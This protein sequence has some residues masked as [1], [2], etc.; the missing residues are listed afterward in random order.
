MNL[1][2]LPRDEQEYIFM[3]H[4]ISTNKDYK[5]YINS[6]ENKNE[7]LRDSAE[8]VDAYLLGGKK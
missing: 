2:E 1:K 7:I 4:N 6:F 3:I 5:Q 8:M